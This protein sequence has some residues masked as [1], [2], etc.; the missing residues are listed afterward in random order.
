MN[1]IIIF[2]YRR[3][4]DKT[5]NSLLLNESSS[6]SELFIFSDG[7]KNEEDLED[8]L[9]VRK[10]LQEIKGF[11]SVKIFESKDNKGLANSI[12]N[13]VNKIIDKYE[14]VIV[15]EDDLI[16]SSDF[17]NYMNS[18]LDFYEKDN[19]IWSI[20]GYSPKIPSLKTYKE[21][22]YLSPRASSWGW[23]TWKNRWETVDWEVKDFEKLKDDKNMIKKF[24][25]G[26]NDLYKMLELQIL[27]KIDSWAIRWVFSQFT[28][29][30]YTVYPV[31]SKITNDGFNDRKGTH[32]SGNSSKW[33]V[34][35]CNIKINFIELEVNHNI[36]KSWK[37]YHDLSLFTKLGYMLN[38]YGG[39]K[40]IK[41]LLNK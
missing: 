41:R 16:V 10:H 24:E 26:G 19:K 22:L 5:I 17:L 7:N 23:A 21:D 37:N 36:I 4:I 8:I 13:G 18:A 30:K 39:Y 15:L 11:K 29:N 3:V 2:T 35:V 25:L 34:E 40:F 38:K 12:I 9:K 1:P 33:D 27:G 28:Q 20:S 14:K 31:K 32:N 6:R